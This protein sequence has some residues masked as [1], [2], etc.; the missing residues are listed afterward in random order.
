MRRIVQL[1]EFAAPAELVL[2]AECGGVFMHKI[3]DL[4][5]SGCAAIHV[6]FT[7]EHAAVDGES[8]VVHG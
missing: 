1:L 4:R 6:H 7:L 5:V 3:S 2:G 8:E